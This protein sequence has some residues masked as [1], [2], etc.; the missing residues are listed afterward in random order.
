MKSKAKAVTN[1]Q[2]FN[3]LHAYLSHKTIPKSVKLSHL[4]NTGEFFVGPFP[5]TLDKRTT[6][7]RLQLISQIGATKLPVFTGIRL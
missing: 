6:P 5:F 2:H 4:I 3:Y 1:T 7:S